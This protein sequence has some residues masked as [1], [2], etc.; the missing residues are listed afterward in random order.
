[1]PMPVTLPAAGFSATE[2]LGK[3]LLERDVLETR[4]YCERLITDT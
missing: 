3:R 4:A 2:M 1:M